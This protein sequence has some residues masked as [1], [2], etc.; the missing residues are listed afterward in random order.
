MTPIQK[1]TSLEPK[2][3]DALRRAWLMAL[4]DVIATDHAPHHIDDK[5]VEYDYADFGISRL[6]TAVS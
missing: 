4:V 2:D 6:E 5:W 1:L 3:V